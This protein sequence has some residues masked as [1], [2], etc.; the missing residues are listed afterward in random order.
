MTPKRQWAVCAHRG[1]SEGAPPGTLE[2]FRRAAE[3][4]FDYVEFDVRRLRDGTLVAFHDASC[5]GRSLRDLA[6]PELRHQAGYDVPRVEDVMDVLRGLAKAHI[7][8]KEEGY[9]A[10]I[11]ALADSLLG[12]GEYVVTTLED[13][14]IARIKR[15]SPDVRAGLSLGRNLATERLRVR[16][17][18]RLSELFPAHR[19]RACGADF[20]SVHHRLAILHV[21]CA[22]RRMGLPAFVW[23]VNDSRLLAYLVSN[24]IVECIVT[25]VP[26]KVRAYRDQRTGSRLTLPE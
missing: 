4:R 12:R 22:A 20:V 6:L 8:L 11:V 7:D 2:A 15:G 9:E 21:L 18:V 26:G 10:E 19:V 3:S 14:V 16:L 25:D 1:G 17:K 23:T 24:R 13:D 5:D